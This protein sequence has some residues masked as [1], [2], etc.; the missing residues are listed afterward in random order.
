MLGALAE[1]IMDLIRETSLWQTKI[2]TVDLR[3]MGGDR[4]EVNA[5]LHEM[6]SNQRI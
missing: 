4:T 3:S 6:V 5:F 1:A 2:A